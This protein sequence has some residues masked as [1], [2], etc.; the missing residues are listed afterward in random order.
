[1]RVTGSKIEKSLVSGN[2]KMDAEAYIIIRLQTLVTQALV[3]STV[4]IDPQ[5][6]HVLYRH[7]NMYSATAG[8]T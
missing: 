4:R 3:K 5:V 8:V 1:M 7:Q 2:T 6:Q